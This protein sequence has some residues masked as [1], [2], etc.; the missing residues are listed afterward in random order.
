MGKGD[1]DGHGT[2][3]A[4][5]TGRSGK[6]RN[7]EFVRQVAEAILLSPDLTPRQSQ[8]LAFLWLRY[9]NAKGQ[10]WPKL[11]SVARYFN[12]HERKIR[13][14]INEMVDAEILVKERRTQSDGRYGANRLTIDIDFLME[15][16]P[17]LDADGRPNKQPA[18]LIR[19]G[20]V[21]PIRSD[22]EPDDDVVGTFGSVPEQDEP[23][24]GGGPLAEDRP[25]A[26]DEPTDERPRA[27]RSEPRKYNQGHQPT[28]SEA[29]RA[30]E[31][32]QV[33]REVR[34][35]ELVEEEGEVKGVRFHNLLDGLL[36]GA[37]EADRVH[38]ARTILRLEPEKLAKANRFIQEALDDE[39]PSLR[40]LTARIHALLPQDDPL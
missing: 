29:S 14:H 1:V 20:T 3:A 16:L 11:K 17:G 39:S 18:H 6:G 23:A 15:N 24:A 36:E 19:T 40:T 31:V 34:F 37:R 4:P 21:T 25:Q 26:N 12:C 28:E 8:V 32:E 38:F 10:M 2:L 13:G 5:R 22:V 33:A 27:G 35:V 30:V 7:P 9:G